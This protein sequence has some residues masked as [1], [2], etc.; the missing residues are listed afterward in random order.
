PFII[1][2]GSSPS[3]CGPERRAATGQTW[4]LPVPV[5]GA[6][7]HARF[8]D[9]A[10]PFGPC[11]GAS[12][13]CCLPRSKQRRHPEIGFRGSMAGL[14]PPLPTLHRRPYG[15][16]RTARGRCGSLL[17]HRSG[18]APPIPCRSP[19]ALRVQ[20]P[21]PTSTVSLGHVRSNIRPGKAKT[22]TRRLTPPPTR[23]EDFEN[24]NVPIADDRGFSAGKKNGSSSSP[25]RKTA[26]GSPCTRRC[27]RVHQ[28]SPTPF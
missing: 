3:R 2:Y 13:T 26:P 11:D 15:R 5:Q 4:D 9:H 6:S 27:R 19:G 12:E 21:Q 20:P 10:G 8:F 16:Q 7:A 24:G 14:C 25:M 28:R 22:L 17:L 23:T 1:G 18:L